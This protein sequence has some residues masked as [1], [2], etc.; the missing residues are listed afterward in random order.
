MC[1]LSPTCA[2]WRRKI[3]DQVLFFTRFIS[4]S[5]S[6]VLAPTGI[7][8][9]SKEKKRQHVLSCFTFAKNKKKVLCLFRCFCFRPVLTGRKT[10]HREKSA[11]FL[12]NDG[13]LMQLMIEIR[14]DSMPQSFTRYVASVWV[15][16]MV[17]TDDVWY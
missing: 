11:I 7:V 6:H 3:N 2:T 5:E 10:D 12:L 1:F 8:P 17:D 9:N 14:P 13:A 15:Q 16:V 4:A